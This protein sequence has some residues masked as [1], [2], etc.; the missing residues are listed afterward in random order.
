MNLAPNILVIDDEK[1]IC[2]SC[3][4]ILSDAGYRVDTDMSGTNG[5]RRALKNPYDAIVLDL[6]LKES[7]GMQLLYGIRKRKP[8]VPVVIITGYPSEETRQKSTTLG[9]TDY[10]TKPFEP[11]EILESIQRVMPIKDKTIP[12]VSQAKPH[13]QYYGTS[14]FYQSSGLVWVGGYMP[15]LSNNTLKSVKLPD[16]GSLIYRGLP[17]VE[18]TLGND[19]RQI[20]PSS[21][22]GKV[23]RVNKQICEYPY[24][25]ILERDFLIKCWIALVEPVNL[26]EDLRASETRSILVFSD[27]PSEENEFY[28]SFLLIS[29]LI[30]KGYTISITSNIDSVLNI[31]SKGATWLLV[32]DAKNLSHSGPESVKRINQEFPDVKVVVFNESDIEFEK[33]YREKKIFYYG[34]NPVSNNEMVDILHCAFN[35]DIKKVILKNPC[36]SRFLPDNISKISIINKYGKKVTL[37]AYNDI[38][39]ISE[40]LGYLLTKDLID[41]AFP[42]K[43]NYSRFQ[44]S[45]DNPAEIYEIAREKE[46]N[47]RI[48]ILQTK[49]LAKIPGSMVKDIQEYNNSNA[50][51]NLLINISVQ[52]SAEKNRE[53]GFDKYTTIALKEIIKMEMISI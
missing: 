32:V 52:P 5:F 48:I 18:V 21:I 22:T 20:I 25:Y 9:V 47:D 53:A 40:G 41:M 30:Y 1:H 15:N 14:W 28:Y 29:R 42:V 12:G 44:K 19:T 51:G 37:L 36:V 17:L 11:S 13:Y 43:T 2:E 7:D 50:S 34:V 49:G 3:D 6:K 39:K 38:L 31:L 24:S 46:K 10:I 8:Y 23:T 16:V 35:D 45:M 4:R 27:K 33:L 26:E